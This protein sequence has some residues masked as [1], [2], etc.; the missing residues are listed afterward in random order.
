MTSSTPGR[1]GGECPTERQLS[2][3]IDGKSAKAF[4]DQ[5]EL[6][7]LDCNGCC[8]RL[9]QLTDMERVSPHGFSELKQNGLEESAIESRL[10]ERLAKCNPMVSPSVDGKV[11]RDVSWFFSLIGKPTT[12]EIQ[13]LDFSSVR[14]AERYRLTKLLSD[15]MFS[16]VFEAV[17]ESLNR[18]VVIKLP[19]PKVPDYGRRVAEEAKLVS[20]LEHPNIVPILDI[21]NWR[22]QI[23]LVY[24][25]IDGETLSSLIQHGG[26]I[27]VELA[28]EIV[29]AIASALQRAHERGVF[30][31]DI[32]P[33]NIMLD[34]N[35]NPVLIDFGLAVRNEN[36]EQEKNFIAGT[37]PYMS[38]EQ[39]SGTTLSTDGRT[40]IYSL[41]A[42]L[43]E[44][45][46]GQRPFSASSRDDLRAMIFDRPARPLRQ[47]NASLPSAIEKICATCL[48][49]DPAARF[50]SAAELLDALVAFRKQNQTGVEENPIVAFRDETQSFAVVPRENLRLSNPAP[51]RSS[52][53]F[54]KASASASLLVWG[55]GSALSL[56]IAGLVWYSGFFSNRA[57]GEIANSKSSIVAEAPSSTG[58]GS[59][60]HFIYLLQA[61]GQ[62]RTRRE[63][64]ELLCESTGELVIIDVAFESGP[65][66]RWTADELKR[67]RES[68]PGRK[69]LAYLSLGEA[70]DYRSYWKSE[71]DAD[72]DG[73][74]DE[75][76]PDFLCDVNEDWEGNYRV[77]YWD[78]EWK[79]IV[80]A[81]VER[82]VE[83]GFDG[84][85]L[86]RVDAYEEQEELESGDYESDRINPETKQSFRKDMLDLVFSLGGR[87]R[88]RRPE[89]LIVPQNGSQLLDDDNYLELIDAIALE[90]L[91]FYE[92]EP[93]DSEDQKR[94][95]KYVSRLDANKPVLLVEYVKGSLAKACREKAHQLGYPLL[96]T[97]A[98]LDRLDTVE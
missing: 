21:G 4:S 85:F 41:G 2:E 44:L 86:D 17:D 90:E 33:A 25:F 79:E 19:S 50:G 12:T 22:N 84:V 52:E 32:K 46:S 38:P 10:V 76:A 47:L 51:E 42:V 20:E 88:S 98:E 14:I 78:A 91:F 70:E 61:D 11:D 31:R 28:I 60:E 7:L 58:L 45:V 1:N 27:D 5:L 54:Q 39:I 74:P 89:F 40:D 68:Q 23:F 83:Q 77:K 94:I 15:S 48:Q 97:N 66:G 34:Q 35:G 3:Y 80:F 67:I 56:T 92:D 29:E 75:A 69:I 57:E 53:K 6:H 43:Y 87:A 30:H 81:E 62:G 55:F 13:D 37:L 36:L 8:S 26:A 9:A 16:L 93:T 49:K 72:S 63:A 82:I 65:S 95:L 59:V 18:K 71:W 64:V 73:S 96:I 24:K